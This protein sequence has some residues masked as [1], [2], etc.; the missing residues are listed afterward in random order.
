MTKLINRDYS[1]NLNY[2]FFYWCILKDNKK[3]M[4]KILDCVL[5]IKEKTYTLR[6]RK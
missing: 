6:V 5:L 2:N 4:M 1:S 3:L